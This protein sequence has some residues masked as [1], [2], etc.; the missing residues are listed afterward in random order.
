M[1][2]LHEKSVEANGDKWTRPEN[3]VGNGAFILETWLSQ[4]HIKLKKNPNYWDASNV[5]LDGVIF[6]PIDDRQAEFK[7]FKAGDLHITK[8]VPIDQIPVIKETMQE[9]YRSNSMYA[10]YYYAFNNT[11]PFLDN[12]KVRQ[13]L[14]LAI[15]RDMIVNQITKGDEN[16]AYSFVPASG[17][18]D[19]S[20]QEMMC[21]DVACKT[22]TQAQREELAVKLF[23]ESNYAKTDPIEIVF[24]TDDSNKKIA[25][26]ISGM[27]KKVLGIDVQLTNKEWKVYLASKEKREYDV[28][29]QRWIADYSDP[30]AFLTLFKSTT[31]TGNTAGQNSPK[32]DS[33]M[34]KSAQTKG[35][36]RKE[37]LMNAEKELMSNF[38]I[39]PI[40][41]FV[42]NCLVSKNV[43]GYKSNSLDHHLSKWIDITDTKKE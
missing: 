19:Y 17:E 38:V 41:Y 22:L 25:I 34:D 31:G 15:D 21:G 12:P 9:N 6:Y 10:T 40:Y 35:Q 24:N 43:S 7:R 3:I 36:E 14:A 28:F 18:V 39:S 32:Y 2:P 37:N 42:T 23:K 11:R 20:P 8:Y 4:D 29:R 5:K 26:A 13:A 30:S 27:W 33:Y 1:V 16:P